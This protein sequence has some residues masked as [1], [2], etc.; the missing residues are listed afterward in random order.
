MF[1]K[2]FLFVGFCYFF[3][4]LT[5]DAKKNLPGNFKNCELIY[6]EDLPSRCN[7]RIESTTVSFQPLEI[8][9]VER[10]NNQIIY[11][12]IELLIGYESEGYTYLQVN[13]QYEDDDTLLYPHLIRIQKT[14]PGDLI[15]H[16]DIH[17]KAKF[18]V[19]Q[20]AILEHNEEEFLQTTRF[21]T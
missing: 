8:T 3:I 2:Y 16:S 6:Q 18:F 20:F 10:G 14:S 4:I 11:F 5:T 19:V 13:H 1:F 17:P 15:Y 7:P 9:Y 21:F 12:K